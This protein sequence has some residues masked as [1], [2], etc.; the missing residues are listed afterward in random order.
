MEISTNYSQIGNDEKILKVHYSA[1]LFAL[2]LFK[3]NLNYQG[4]KITMYYIA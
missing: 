2:D 1:M 4:N 3:V